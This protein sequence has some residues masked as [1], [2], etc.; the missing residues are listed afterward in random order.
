MER[1]RSKFKG[2][3]VPRQCPLVFQVKV[4]WRGDTTF[5]CK[6]GRDEMWSR[7]SS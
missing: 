7:E 3:K 4:G 1:G 2:M 6:E 5:G